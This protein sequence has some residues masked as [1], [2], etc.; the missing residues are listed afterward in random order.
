[1][2]STVRD[3]EHGDHLVNVQF[4]VRTAKLFEGTDESKQPKDVFF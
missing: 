3:D 1:M 4:E 2:N